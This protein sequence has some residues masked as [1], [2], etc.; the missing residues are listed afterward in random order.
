[1]NRLLHESHCLVDG[2][3]TERSSSQMGHVGIKIKN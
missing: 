3:S 1:M 2:T